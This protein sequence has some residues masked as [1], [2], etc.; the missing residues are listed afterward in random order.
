MQATADE[1]V[2][3][4]AAAPSGSGATAGS[5][6]ALALVPL[7]RSF[8]LGSCEGGVPCREEGIAGGDR[9]GGIAAASRDT[10]DD[11]CQA[12]ADYPLCTPAVA[13]SPDAGAAPIGSARGYQGFSAP[14]AIRTGTQRPRARSY[15]HASAVL[16]A[17]S[18]RRD[19][20]L[21]PAPLRTGLAVLTASGS[22]KPQRAAQ[23]REDAGSWL[24]VPVARR[25]Q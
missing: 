23:V 4:V 10:A 19:A 8:F 5:S 20:L 24:P 1:V 11:G 2:G 18:G 7:A 14:S 17:K 15:V 13:S 12:T 25:W 16:S 3:V 21:R 9:G 22:G 6:A